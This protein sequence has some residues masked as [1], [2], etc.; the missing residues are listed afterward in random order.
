MIFPKSYKYNF[1]FDYYI[2]VVNGGVAT[3][4]KVRSSKGYLSVAVSQWSLHSAEQMAVGGVV[5]NLRDSK[6]NELQMVDGVPFDLYINKT[7]PYFDNSTEVSG[8]KHIMSQED[9]NAFRNALLA[10]AGGLN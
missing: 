8:Y 6:G 1:T 5:R 7:V 10:L 4:Q 3:Y 9:K 2:Q